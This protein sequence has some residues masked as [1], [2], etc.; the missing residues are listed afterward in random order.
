MVEGGEWLAWWTSLKFRQLSFSTIWMNNCWCVIGRA[1]DAN[2][3]KTLV[4]T[5]VHQ[6][7]MA[8]ESMPPLE[9][10][11]PKKNLWCTCR[12]RACCPDG[13]LQKFP[14]A[15][16]C[17]QDRDHM[18]QLLLILVATIAPI[19]L[20]LWTVIGIPQIVPLQWSQNPSPAHCKST[21][22]RP[23]RKLLAIHSAQGLQSQSRIPFAET[24]VI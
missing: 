7:N 1:P 6:P 19:C 18:T 17:G 5:S 2:Q 4:H 10:L 24:D 11:F 23:S 20:C 3:T 21:S 16:L 12:L 13:Y 8:D 15:C 9:V 22:C 14:T